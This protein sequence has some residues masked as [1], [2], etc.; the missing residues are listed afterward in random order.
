MSKVFQDESMK[1]TRLSTKMKIFSYPSPLFS[2]LTLFT[3]V[4][5]QKLIGNANA[6]DGNTKF[7]CPQRGKA[8][9]KKDCLVREI[10]N[11][12]SQITNK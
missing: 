7:V 8:T 9:T 6:D 4:L 10:T 3:A 2:R 11:Y 5:Y 1:K 12:K